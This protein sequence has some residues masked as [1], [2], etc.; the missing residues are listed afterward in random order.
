MPGSYETLLDL[1]TDNESF[2][3]VRK[4][5]VGSTG[6]QTLLGFVANSCLIEF[7]RQSQT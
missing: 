1:L 4:W 2:F 7:P 5:Y 3:I 6:E